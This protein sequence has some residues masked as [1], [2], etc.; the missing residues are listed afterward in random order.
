[1]LTIGLMQYDISWENS[2]ETRKTISGILGEISSDTHLDWLIFPEM[3]L[4]G[5]S[6]NYPKTEASRSDLDFFSHIA[7]IHH[8]YVTFGAVF[9]QYNCAIT[10]NPQGDIIHRY[11][12]IHL[13]SYENENQVYLA[14][15][16]AHPFT[17]HKI[18]VLPAICYD[19]RFS[20]LF[21]EKATSTDLYCVIANF[22]GQR[23]THW[24]SLLRARAIEN[25]AFV[26]GVNRV[27]N[28]PQLG[29]LGGSQVIH[30]SGDI[31]L[32]AKDQVGCFLVSIDP[33]DVQTIRKQF[34]FLLDRI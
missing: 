18:Q 21:W 27:G 26:L 34:P 16:K 12:K 24:E 20:D 15:T 29:Y 19:L 5:F 2:I 33:A 28:S 7:Q 1:M 9:S 14:G 11:Q 17:L 6:L 8:C 30:P 4:T 23:Q 13:F 22:P 32:D 3:S 25:Q 10:L 31:L